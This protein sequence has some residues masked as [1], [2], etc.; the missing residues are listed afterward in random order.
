MTT[1]Y[2][3]VRDQGVIFMRLMAFV[4][5]VDTTGARANVE[6]VS[7]GDLAIKFYPRRSALCGLP[8]CLVD[9][10]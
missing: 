5:E 9:E 6:V 3:D 10:A 2:L 7:S 1:Q 8:N 4:A